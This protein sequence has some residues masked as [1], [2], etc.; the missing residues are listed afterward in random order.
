MMG[1]TVPVL[2]F[3]KEK[4]MKKIQ[5]TGQARDANICL[6]TEDGARWT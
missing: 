2:F 4:A 5:N 6:T 1:S 3:Q